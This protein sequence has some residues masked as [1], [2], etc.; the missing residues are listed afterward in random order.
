[1]DSLDSAYGAGWKRETSIVFRNPSGVFCY[2][3]LP[4]HDVS[5]PGRPAR[6][7]GRGRAYRIEVVGPGVTP[8]LVVQVADPGDYDP[9]DPTKVAYEQQ[10]NKR[11]LQ[12]A[13]G[14]HFCPTQQ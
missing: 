3:F 11:L 8:N 10:A 4:T 13:A 7:A 5:L 12:L 14:D 6:P 9:N 2:A 1:M